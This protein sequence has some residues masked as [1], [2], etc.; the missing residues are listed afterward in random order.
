MTQKIK[1][2][3]AL[4]GGGAKGLAHIGVLKVLEREGI[5]IS[6]IAGT[7]AGALLGSAYALSISLTELETEVKKLSALG[8]WNDILSLGDIRHSLIGN[9]DLLAY[10]NRLLK[11]SDFQHLKIP[12]S[13][14]A[15]SLEDG[16]EIILTQGSLAEAVLASSSIPGVLPPVFQDGLY[17]IDGGVVNQ[18]PV[19]VVDAM[20]VDLVIAVDLMLNAHQDLMDPNIIE[21][22]LQSYEIIRKQSVKYSLQ[23]ARPGYILI[24]PVF[25][26]MADTFK[27][28]NAEEFIRAGE[29]AAEAVLPLLLPLAKGEVGRG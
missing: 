2:G 23:Q 9:S 28:Q 13:I 25:S 16:R 12:L 21:V 24:Q 18:T 22:I 1:I 5:E 27:F 15:T 7:S 6:A 8:A 29:L 14:V 3:L 19:S 11:F 4:G 17:L 26:A 10:L 20:G